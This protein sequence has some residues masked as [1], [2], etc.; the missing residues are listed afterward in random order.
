MSFGVSALKFFNKFFKLPP[1]PFNMRN[2]GGKTYAEWQFENGERTIEFYKEFV[3]SEEI[4]KDKTVLDVG[5][6]AGGK[7]LYYVTLGATKVV[8]IDIVPYYKEQSDEL[9]SKLGIDGFEFR[10]E[11]AASL[12]F[13]D[14]TFDT[15]IMNDAME[16]VAEPE[17][18]LEELKRVLKPGGRIF[19]N[20][21]PYGHP[22]GAHLSDA[23]GIPWVQS[24]YSE[25]AMIAAYKDLVKDKPDGEERINFRISKDENGNE[26][27]SYINKMTIKRFKKI[28]DGSGFKIAYYREVPLRNVFKPLAHGLTKEHFVRMVV[29]V[30]EK[31]PGNNEQ[32]VSSSD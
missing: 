4:F 9:V 22:Y 11:D 25:K 29:C 17:K 31:I 28:R 7:S 20:F 18:V 10:C 12:S 26:Y 14:D 3:P 24:F 15:V 13:P 27:F 6:G 19:V 21:P 1:H 32:K 5:C 16:H 23:I 2:E 8:G 30:F